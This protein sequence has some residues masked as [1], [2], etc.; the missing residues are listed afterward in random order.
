MKPRAAALLAAV[1][2]LIAAVMTAL[3]WVSLE[4]AGLPMSWAGL[5]FHY[6]EYLMPSVPSIVPL[7][8]A[9][10]FVAF[11]AFV[12]LGVALFSGPAQAQLRRWLFLG[13]AGLAA[14]VAVVLVVAV[15]VPQMLYGD[16]PGHLADA[17]GGIERSEV[18]MGRDVLKV[19]A[20]LG[21]AF[22]L[23]VCSGVALLGFRAH[24]E[25]GEQ[26]ESA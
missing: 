6:G 22:W 10:V 15:L 3:P 12:A 20:I 17:V 9:V 11:E 5:G 25:R 18:H 13:L 2:A 24:A 14:A 4:S 23:L 16:M 19:P 26:W 8:W 7:G 21:T 1:A